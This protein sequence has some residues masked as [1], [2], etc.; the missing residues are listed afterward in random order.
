MSRVRE[1]IHIRGENYYTSAQFYL[2][3]SINCLLV[4]T[5]YCFCTYSLFIPVPV[6][7]PLSH[8]FS[9]HCIVLRAIERAN[10]LPENNNVFLILILIMTVYYILD[11]TTRC[12]CCYLH[13]RVIISITILITYTLLFFDKH[14]LKPKHPLACLTNQ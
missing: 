9:Y 6:L 8:L 11:F 10:F 1:L 12:P 7:L 2:F 3:I 13:Q 4:L 14:L 5:A